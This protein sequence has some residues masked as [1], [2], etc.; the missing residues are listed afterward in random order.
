MIRPLIAD[1]SVFL[2]TG[3]RTTLE[4][5]EDIAVVGESEQTAEALSL[6]ERLAPDAG[7]EGSDPPNIRARS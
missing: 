1:E 2:R 4:T 7:D 3:I 6:V 5:Q